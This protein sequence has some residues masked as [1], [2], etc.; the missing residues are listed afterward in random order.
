MSI[1][2]LEQIIEILERVMGAGE[3]EAAAVAE[4]LVGLEAPTIEAVTAILEESFI[5]DSV[6]AIVEAAGEILAVLLL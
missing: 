1:T 2:P 6:A 4:E 5:G 3:E